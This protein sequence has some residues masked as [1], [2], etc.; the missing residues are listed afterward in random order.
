MYRK[1]L[2]LC[3]SLSM[4]GVFGCDGDS[5]NC[6][7]VADAGTTQ[8]VNVTKAAV[9]KL[10][11]FDTNLSNPPGQSCA[12]CHTP[13]TGFV[14]P[15]QWFPTSQGANPHL[16]GNRNAPTAAYAAFSP[17]FH[18]DDTEGLYVGGQFW[19]GRA[20]NLVEQAKGPFLNPVEMGLAD[21]QAAVDIVRNSEYADLMELVYGADIWDD[22][23]AAYDAIADAVAA[24]EESDEVNRF[25][26]KYD[27]YLAGTTSLTAQELRGLD[28]F[29]DE[30]K[31]NCAA[32]HPSQPG[33]GGEAP[34]F[35][36]FTYDNLGTPPNPDNPF[37]DMPAEHNP[38]GQGFVDLG[39]GG[40]LEDP[41]EY[42]KFKVPTLR[43]I[44]LTAPYMHNG[45][46]TSLHEVVDFYNTRDAK[47]IWGDQKVAE[48]V[49]TD[50]MGDLGLTLSEVDDI[51]AFLGTLTDGWA[52]AP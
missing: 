41:T 52:P 51:E 38:D 29:E 30:A 1:H 17:D 49:N 22:T 7:V 3:V 43:N 5:D 19:D 16:F 50:E 11:F 46:F 32:C 31:G 45:V 37:Y 20:T 10:I 21:E 15:H 12:S 40:A 9:G 39:L 13:D 24:Y 14:E 26:S 6:P 44:S 2:I 48:N 18:Y 35:T 4:L 23:L 36:D 34:L 27:A 42:G 28:L 25:T 47:D 8:P 33:P